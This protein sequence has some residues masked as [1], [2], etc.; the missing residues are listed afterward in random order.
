M[1]S[2]AQQIGQ[3]HA[4]HAFVCIE[5]HV[6]GKKVGG[7]ATYMRIALDASCKEVL[8]DFL[9]THASDYSS[10]LPES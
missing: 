10:P 6:D 3:L 2:I 9:A 4:S 5:V 7:N 8:F 1:S